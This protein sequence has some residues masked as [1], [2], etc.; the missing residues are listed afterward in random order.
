M[1]DPLLKARV[2][3]S[4]AQEK[5]GKLE[6]RLAY[7]PLRNAAS[8][9]ERLDKRT[10]PLADA[11]ERAQKLL[12]TAKKGQTE[13]Q[14]ARV[15]LAEAQRRHAAGSMANLANSVGVVATLG[16]VATIPP[17]A[18]DAPRAAELEVTLRKAA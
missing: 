3:E 1:V 11:V 2:E 17:D 7:I 14:V 5:Q 18:R 6:A 10:Q 12:D 13:H 4:A 16:V 9:V 15:A 8:K